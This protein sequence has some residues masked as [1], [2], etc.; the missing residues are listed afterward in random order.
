VITIALVTGMLSFEQAVSTDS[1]D[2]KTLALL[3]GMMVVVGFLRPCYSLA[4]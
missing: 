2:Y 3:F 4:G 1:I